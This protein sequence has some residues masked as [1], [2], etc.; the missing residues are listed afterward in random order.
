MA[1]TCR[2][3][4]EP[5]IPALDLGTLYLSNFFDSKSPDAPSGRLQ[6]GV[7]KESQLLQ[8]METFPP[9]LMYRQYWY[10]SGTNAQM[11]RELRD[12][13]E[14]VPGW[15]RLAEGD[16]VLDIGCND[17][18]LLRQYPPEL[19]LVK[20]GIDPAKNIAPLG[21]QASTLHA[22]D[23][24]SKE[25]YLALTQGKKARVI[26][27]IAMFY[28][29]D[30][31][32]SFVHDIAECLDD[33]GIWIMQL[34]YTPLMLKQNA[35]DNIVHEHIEYYSLASVDALLRRHSLKIMSVELN[36]TNAGSFRLVI[37]HD[38]ND[39]SQMTLF[40]R[41]IGEYQ[42]NAM[43]AYEKSI[44]LNTIEA[45]HAFGA[46]VEALKTHTLE[47]LSDLK[48]KG[49][50]VY[51]YGASTKG[52]TLLQYYGID[53][54]LIP[55]IAERQTQKVGKLTAGSW[56][57]I[58]SEDEMRKARPDYLFVLPWHFINEF[59]RRE[60]EFLKRGGK[61]IVPLPELQVIG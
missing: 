1:A 12:I 33:Q 35:F 8:L 37:T 56:I 54:S 38:R 15:V 28:D 24:F 44:G 13:V 9:E 30:D 11:T 45:V 60:S 2:V 17:G 40:D 39:C 27:S 47:L 31:P 41:D 61:F 46:R 36:D 48:K 6:L 50:V 53:T 49:K 22:C 51:G 43:L 3:S 23:Y 16:H 34:S 7:A 57:P 55:A 25:T 20:V 19:G 58:I 10:L 18:T 14:I 5:L 4:G 29:L 59:Y 26:T 32:N 42:Y 21:R 52:N